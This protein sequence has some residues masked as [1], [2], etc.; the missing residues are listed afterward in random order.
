[1]QYA[2]VEHGQYSVVAHEH[3]QYRNS[4]PY[5]NTQASFGYLILLVLQ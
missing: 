1:M 2:Q 4:A 3:G 5:S